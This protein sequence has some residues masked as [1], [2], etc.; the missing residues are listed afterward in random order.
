MPCGAGVL[1]VLGFAFHGNTLSPTAVR[2]SSAAQAAQHIVS[3]ASMA[4]PMHSPV[5][6]VYQAVV[7]IIL[8]V[9]RAVARK[10]HG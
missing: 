9:I 4:A 3:R 5:R 8:R 7:P 1:G 6:I 2:A 10:M